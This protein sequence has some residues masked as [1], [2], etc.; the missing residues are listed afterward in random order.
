MK[1]S[2]NSSV[3]KIGKASPQRF[4]RAY[5]LFYC[6][7]FH[8]DSRSVPVRM[9][10]FN[11]FGEYTVNIFLLNIQYQTFRGFFENGMDIYAQFLVTGWN[12]YTSFVKLKS[13][14][15]TANDLIATQHQGDDRLFKIERKIMT[16]YIRF[17]YIQFTKRNAENSSFLDLLH[18]R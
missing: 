7:F 14:I 18:D 12:K 9:P 2:V 6:I 15:L 4:I 8:H 13:F 11:H 5:E 3:I 16:D 1:I 17:K 10:V